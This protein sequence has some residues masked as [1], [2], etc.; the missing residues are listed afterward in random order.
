MKLCLHCRT[1]FAG[2]S[3]SCPHCHFEPEILDGFRSFAT[4]LAHANDGIPAGAHHDLD[5]LQSGSFWFRARNSLIQDLVRCYFGDADTVLEIGCG[6]GFVLSGIRAALPAAYLVGSEIYSHGL[7]YAAERIAP[8]CELL[9]MDALAIP[10]SREF[11]LIGAF[12]VLEHID[13]DEAA[14]A[15]V[16]RAL[17]P[18]GGFLLTVPQHAWLWSPV[19]AASLHRRRYAPGE[20][21]GK[22]RRHGFDVLRE[23]SFVSLLLP[24]MLLQRLRA[25]RSGYDPRDE[26]R[27]PSVIDRALEL[28]LDIERKLIGAG[29]RLPV[30]GSQAV[31]ARLAR[32]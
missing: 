2:A 25:R 17:R 3:W 21:A 19:D 8:P 13:H 5:R 10:Y 14:I 31:A 22:L 30:G 15:Q 32:S 12:D 28:L 20:L 27:L 9:Q 7:P 1:E 29:L 16:A 4:A 26:L 18:G 11:D 23:T 6:S 24:L